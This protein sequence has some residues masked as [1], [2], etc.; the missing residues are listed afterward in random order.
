MKKGIVMEV[1]PNAIIMMTPEG[2]FISTK[3]QAS[4][5][6][7]IGEELTFY[8]GMIEESTSTI[9]QRLRQKSSVKP[10]LSSAAALLMLLFIFLPIIKEPEVYAY[11]SV[12]INPSFEL[13][14]DQD[15]QVVD[16]KP[17]N[18]EAENLLKVITDPKGKSV[19]TVTEQIIDLSS[20]EGFMNDGKRVTVTTVFT[21]EAENSDK[22]S[23]K[24]AINKFTVMKFKEASVDISLIDSNSQVREEAA[25]AGITTGQL[26]KEKEEAH[27]KKE[28]KK[29]KEKKPVSPGQQEDIKKQKSPETPIEKSSDKR[30][31]HLKEKQAE[32]DRSK[33]NSQG[34]SNKSNKGSQLQ[35][36]KEINSEGNG[37]QP[38]ASNNPP[39]NHP[40]TKGN[41]KSDR[42]HKQEN[43]QRDKGK[44]NAPNKQEDKQRGNGK[45]N[46]PNKQ[47]DNK[48]ND[49][50]K[51][52]DKQIDEKSKDRNN[53]GDKQKGKDNNGND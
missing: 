30:P 7:E 44:S 31:D 25:A 50:Q 48:S 26:L 43:S 41:G 14:I 38:D 49:S 4:V 27:L 52:E 5:R 47:K 29:L 12:D 6:Y 28:S 34:K 13:S 3:K 9:F 2:E 37:R 19:I 1:K 35:K 39:S 32:K 53:Q 22:S 33:S 15:H 51:Q 46:T 10:V 40:D 21:E 24:K 42:S 17:F 8:P 16:I 45:S 20:K 36:E 23:I 18:K 11:V